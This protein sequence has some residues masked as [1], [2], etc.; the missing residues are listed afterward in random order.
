MSRIVFEHKFYLCG[1]L[2]KKNRVLSRPSLWMTGAQS[3][4]GSLGDSE[5]HISVL[6]YL[7]RRKRKIFTYQ[8]LFIIVGGLCPEGLTFQYF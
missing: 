6:F 8:I 4:Q 7:R 1:D 5:E 3:H 2:R